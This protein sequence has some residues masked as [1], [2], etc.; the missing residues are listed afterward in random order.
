MPPGAGTTCSTSA[1][2]WERSRGAG[3]MGF[4]PSLPGAGVDAGSGARPGA[5]AAAERTTTSRCPRRPPGLRAPGPPVFRAVDA[6]PPR[7]TARRRSGARSW[8]IDGGAGGVPA[9]IGLGS[10]L[11]SGAPPSRRSLLEGRRYRRASPSSPTTSTRPAVSGDESD[12]VARLA[13]ATTTLRGARRRASRS[14]P[15]WRWRPRAPIV[16]AAGHQEH[17]DN[18]RGIEALDPMLTRARIWAGSDGEATL[19]ETLT[20]MVREDPGQPGAAS[21]LGRF[22]E[23]GGRLALARVAYGLAAFV[24]PESR[25]RGTSR[26]SRRPGTS[27]P[28]LSRSAAPPTIPTSMSRRAGRWQASRPRCSASAPTSPR[29]NRRRGAASRRRAPPSCAASAIRLAR[30]RS[31]S[32]AM[33]AAPRRATSAAACA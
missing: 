30:P 14:R 2:G 3:R 7:S 24:V 21:A 10:A 4:G 23:T 17:I 13:I 15:R 33:P 6:A 8:A 19:Y 31:S 28:R 5:G 12:L 25:R 9:L 32:F 27:S 18:N 1:S 11:R 22:A 20:E 16:E 26:G 29:R